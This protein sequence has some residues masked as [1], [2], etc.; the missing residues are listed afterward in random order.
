P[1]RART[2]KNRFLAETWKDDLSDLNDGELAARAEDFSLDKIPAEVLI[3]TVGVDVADDRLESTT[4]G[5]T[6][7]GTMLVL[8]HRVHWGSPAENFCWADLDTLLKSEWKHPNGGKLK[9][10]ACCIDSGDGDWTDRVYAF[11]FPRAGRRVMAI[12]GQYGNRP[13]IQC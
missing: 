7:D 10:D 3:V 5:W 11:C 1:E 9:V 6:A 12:K 2:F 8:G 13:S 4:I